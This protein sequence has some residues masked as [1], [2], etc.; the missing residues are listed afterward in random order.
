MP[1][2]NRPPVAERLSWAHPSPALGPPTGAPGMA[3]PALLCSPS[4]LSF[5]LL[6]TQWGLSLGPLPFPRGV[7]VSQAPADLLS[8][9][10]RERCCQWAWGSPPLA[11]APLKEW[12][13][14]R[15]WLAA[16]EM[17][18]KPGA[19]DSQLLSSPFRGHHRPAAIAQELCRALQRV[20]VPP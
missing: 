7:A 3:L 18:S 12:G 5:A 2:P 11:G 1:V 17:P 16:F 9:R 15:D 4:P 19:S 10:L 20:L 13:R 14:A 6:S 8:V